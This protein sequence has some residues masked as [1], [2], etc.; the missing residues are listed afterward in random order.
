MDKSLDREDTSNP[1]ELFKFKQLV[2]REGKAAR[3]VVSWTLAAAD[4]KREGRGRGSKNGNRREKRQPNHRR[5]SAGGS[6]RNSS[7]RQDL[8]PTTLGK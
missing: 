5:T 2:E 1:S 4:K 8:P 6:T 7:S 3:N